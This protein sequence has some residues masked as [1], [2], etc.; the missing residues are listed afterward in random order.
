MGCMKNRLEKNKKPG[1]YY[2][3]A[4]DGLELPII[5]ITHPAFA[6]HL[7]DAELA[8][9]SQHYA[10][11]TKHQKGFIQRHLFQFFLKRSKLGRGLI[12]AAGGFLSGMS[13]YLLKIGAD[14]LGS[15]AGN[16]DRQIAQAL[17]SLAA[18]LRLQDMAHLLA[19]ALTPLLVAQP[20]KPLHLLNIAGGPAMDS[21]NAIHLIPKEHLLGRKITIHVLDKDT[22]GPLFGKRALAAWL[23][24]KAPLAGLD[25][26][27]HH[28][29]YD[30]A[31]ISTLQSLIENLSQNGNIIAA[32]SEGG[33]FEY[34]SDAKIVSHLQL[35]APHASC[36]V[37]SITRKCGKNPINGM[38]AVRPRTLDEFKNL[39]QQG[40]YE[41]AQVLEGPLG[42]NLRLQAAPHNV[43]QG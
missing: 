35:L 22:D 13:T 26:E 27:F 20:K 16:I 34:G 2:A 10:Q 4:S 11:Q 40:G 24:E 37:G 28:I 23:S 41:V 36:V 32:S 1:V 12:G 14:N 8:E 38:M 25:I 15:Y 19:D 43:R 6:I 17:P 29:S 7:T 33:L 39:A 18:R 21:L 5:D 30:W 31:K 9:I 3:I 42:Y